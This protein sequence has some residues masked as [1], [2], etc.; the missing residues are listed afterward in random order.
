MNILKKMNLS[1]ALWQSHFLIQAG[2]L[3]FEGNTGKKISLGAGTLP[4]TLPFFRLPGG[5]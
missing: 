1:F 4:V 3:M 2:L 5:V